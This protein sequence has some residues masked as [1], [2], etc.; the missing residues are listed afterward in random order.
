MDKPIVTATN[1][2]IVTHLKGFFIW[3]NVGDVHDVIDKMASVLGIEPRL[4][5]Y[6][7]C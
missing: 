6:A 1:H 7:S 5:Q 2:S 4:S 3:A